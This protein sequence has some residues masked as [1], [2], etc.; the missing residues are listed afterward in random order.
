M[1]ILYFHQYFSTPDGAAGTRS[2]EI[3]KAL[4]ASGH[5]VTMICGSGKHLKIDGLRQVRDGEKRGAVDGIDVIQYELPYSNRDSFIRRAITF[6]RYALKSIRVVFFLDYDLIYA[7][8]TPLTAAIPGIAAKLTMRGKP[9]VFEVRDLWPELPKAMGVIRNPIVLMAMSALE[10][11]AYRS[12]DMCVGLAP[13]IVAGIRKRSS[14][15]LPVELIPNSCDLSLFRPDV[16]PACIKGVADGTFVALFAGAHGIA[17]GLDAVL[18]VAEELK[19][20]GRG[21]IKLVF[22][23]D[24]NRKDALVERAE[25][26]GLDNCVFLDS[27]PKTSMP[28]LLVRADLGLMILDDVPAFYNGTSPNKFFDYISSGLPVLINYPGWLSELVVEH[29]CGLSVDPGVAVAFADALESL[30]DQP[31]QLQR[32]GRSARDL[33]EMKFNRVRLNEHLLKSLTRF[34]PNVN[35]CL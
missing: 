15:L 33:G 22:I 2:Y 30:A 8:S 23:G 16:N 1:H 19:R 12:A 20:R 4:V 7:T 35:K 6:I 28:G 17:N 29:E 21:D 3:A 13:G 31:E 26:S 5:R 10:W 25:G 11:L 18:D 32:M 9:F 14:S 34:I 24:G 27:V